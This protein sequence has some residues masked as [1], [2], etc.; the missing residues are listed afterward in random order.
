MKRFALSGIVIAFFIIF[1]LYY[2][3]TGQTFMSPV[4]SP[5]PT[6]PTAPL[7][8]PTNQ[9][10]VTN[11]LAPPTNAPIPTSAPTLPPPRSGLKDGTFVGDTINAFYAD[12][13][14][15]AII[16]GGKLTDVQFL[17]YPNDSG[18][19]RQVSEYSMPILK[20]EA[21]TA[22]SAQVDIVSGATDTSQAFIQSLQ[23]ALDRAKS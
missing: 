6:T 14:V 18:H 22:Q 7:P 13:Q 11:A 2:R 16:Q 20:S 21:I 10:M 4:P 12:F 8:T 15:Q 3:V 1:S 5:G 9:P 17:K 19:S 23:S